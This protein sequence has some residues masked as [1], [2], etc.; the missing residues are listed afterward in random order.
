VKLAEARQ[1][2]YQMS[3][4]NEQRDRLRSGERGSI[5]VMTAIFMALL[6]L[7]LGLCIDVSRIYLVRAELQNA[8][9][10]AALAAA[11]ALNGGTLGIDNAVTQATSA[12]VNTQ[13]LRAKTNVTIATVEFAIEVDGTYLS[14]AD[15][16][17]A[18]TVEHIQ[19]VR[20]TTQSTSTNILFA[21]SAL[22]ASHAESRQA[23]AG[24]SVG[25]NGICDFFPAAVALDDANPLTPLVFDMPT[26]GTPITLNFNQG[27]GVGITLANGD[28]AIL[29]VPQITGSGVGETAEL[30]AGIPNFCKKLGDQIHM[31]PS[32]N[33]NN[34]PLNCGDG[35][36]TRF[37]T[38]AV[39]YGNALKPGTYPPDKNINETIDHTQYVN[40]SPLTSPNPNGSLARDGRRILV[41]PIIATGVT[42]P[43]YASNILAWGVFF[44]K[45]KAPVPNNCSSVPG[46][47]SIPAEYVG[48]APPGNANGDPTCSSPITTSV[49]YR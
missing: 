42:S 6:F 40:G 17:A 32:S 21:S 41:V 49:L 19:Y 26:P 33:Q 47:G 5:I 36:N 30:C 3:S 10:A 20:V 1:E 14:A 12:I 13:G 24:M 46:C 15:A 34:G 43:P 27:T 25:L 28:Y 18:G 45:N 29:E 4:M 9:D 7:M 44:L 35:M 22:G 16:K 39:G 2:V 37:N 38:Y 8:A 31:T 11:R 23:V 48:P